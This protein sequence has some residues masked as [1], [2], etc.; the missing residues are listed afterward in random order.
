MASNSKSHRGIALL[1]IFLV[2]F[3]A[4]A[5][6]DTG[7]YK[8]EPL[9]KVSP[10]LGDVLGDIESRM[11][12]GHQYR[13]NDQITWA[14]ETTHGLNSRWRQHFPNKA[15]LYVLQSRLCVLDHPRVKLS[16]V[17]RAV[18]R[19]LRG[20]V[21]NLYLTQAQQWWNNEPLYVFDEWVAYCN[22]TAA[23]MDLDEKGL[24]RRGDRYYGA[25]LEK[26]IQFVGYALVVAQVGHEKLSTERPNKQR[27]KVF[28]QWHIERSMRLYLSGRKSRVIDPSKA[29]ETLRSLRQSP[30]A[31]D[32]REF[33]RSFFG[34]DW[35]KSILGI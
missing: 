8:V 13:D 18:P 27:F 15:C 1:V 2:F 24:L 33:S 14:H 25:D 31:T 20:D 7:W 34:E 5:T 16:D 6:Q 30:D 17:A 3:F 22:G 11:P 9:R 4:G 32:L 10:Q 29:D 19:S 12:A 35:C 21:Y 23:I 28:T 26:V